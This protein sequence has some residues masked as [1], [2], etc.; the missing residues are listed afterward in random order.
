MG[1]RGMRGLPDPLRAVRQRQP[2][3][4]SRDRHP[5]HSPVHP[6]TDRSEEYG[7]QAYAESPGPP[8][9]GRH[10]HGTEDR[11]GRG[12]APLRAGNPAVMGSDPQDPGRTGLFCDR[13][14]L[15]VKEKPDRG[16]DRAGAGALPE[17]CGKKIHL[18][19]NGTSESG[20]DLSDIPAVV[21]LWVLYGSSHGRRKRS[22]FLS[23]GWKEH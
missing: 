14:D 9:E 19:G 13:T 17:I 2:L 12:P 10:P 16:R 23:G 6:G 18:C 1:H 5:G 15:S 22:R 4:D 21:V 20:G 8:D 11:E 7:G 3:Q